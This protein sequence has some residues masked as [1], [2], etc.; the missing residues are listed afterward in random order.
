MNEN[1][2]KK[3]ITINKEKWKSHL[4]DF[5][6]PFLFV[7]LILLIIVHFSYVNNCCNDAVYISIPKILNFGEYES[8]EG[9]KTIFVRGDFENHKYYLG[10]P[11]VWG[12]S[13]I[14]YS[15]FIRLINYYLP[16]V[17]IEKWKLLFSS[18]F[19][20]VLLIKAY[21]HFK[22]NYSIKVN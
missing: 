17:L 12:T 18:T 3:E 4:K 15:Y 19:L 22:I 2:E 8:Y 10:D 7:L 5:L 21:K 11:I 16:Y 6:Y 9:F 14:Y 20:I 13:E 1:L